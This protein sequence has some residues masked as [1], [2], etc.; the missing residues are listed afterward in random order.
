[1]SVR[2][3]LLDVQRQQEKIDAI[4]FCRHCRTT[5]PLFGDVKLSFFPARAVEGM[6]SGK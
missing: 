4:S 6:T 1:M 3:C 5:R 2:E